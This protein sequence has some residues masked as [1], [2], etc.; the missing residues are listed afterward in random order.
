MQDIKQNCRDM[1]KYDIE[2]MML[3]ETFHQK[4]TFQTDKG[5]KQ[6]PV[7]TIQQ[8]KK[9]ITQNNSLEFFEKL[10]NILY[11]VFDKEINWSRRLEKQFMDRYCYKYSEKS[12]SKHG[13]RD[14]GC[15]EILVNDVKTQIVKEFQRH[16]KTSSHGLFLTMKI[17]LRK[18]KRVQRRKGTFYPEMVKGDI[19]QMQTKDQVNATFVEESITVSD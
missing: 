6:N 14:K 3:K 15:F 2:N 9:A 5:E 19:R 12:K 11:G 16:G 8:L 4:V 10:F 13:Q 18:G 17:K 1:A 7:K